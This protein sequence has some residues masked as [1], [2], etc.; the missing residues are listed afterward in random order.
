MVIDPESFTRTV[1]N[2]FHMSFLV[3]DGHAKISEENI[4]EHSQPPEEGDYENRKARR[5]QFVLKIDF[6]TWDNLKND[7]N[8][9]KSMIPPFET[10]TE[11]KSQK[12]K[13]TAQTRTAKFRSGSG[14]GNDS[15]QKKG[16]NHR[17]N[18]KRK[19]WNPKTTDRRKMDL[20]KGE[21]NNAGNLNLDYPTA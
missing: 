9:T 2:I 21:K 20:K 13:K 16:T 7:Y 5:H 15:P 6:Q 4:L 11:R 8:I 10:E 12:G 14:N 1:E 17:K 3:K 19:I 18:V